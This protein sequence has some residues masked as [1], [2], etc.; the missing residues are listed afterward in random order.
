MFTIKDD[1]RTLMNEDDA[2]GSCSSSQQVCEIITL[3]PLIHGIRVFYILLVCDWT[4]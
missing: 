2:T 1:I 4:M 3:D